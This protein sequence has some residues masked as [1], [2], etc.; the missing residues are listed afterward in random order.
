MT[1]REI[2]LYMQEQGIGSSNV[3]VLGAIRYTLK[4]NPAAEPETVNIKTTTVMA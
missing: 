2:A 1:K 4:K 3:D